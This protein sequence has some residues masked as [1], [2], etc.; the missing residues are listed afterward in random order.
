MTR[1]QMR[2]VVLI[3]LL[4][5]APGKVRA[6]DILQEV[7][8]DVL[9]FVAVH[10]LG[11]VDAKAKW[12]SLEL[13]NNAFSPLAFLK[14]VTNVQDGLNLEGDFLLAVYPDPRGDKS[15]LR[16]GV[17]L[18]VADYARFS[19]SIGANSLDGISTVTIA[20]EDLLVAR[21]GEWALVMDTDQRERMT[22]LVAAS[23]SPPVSPQIAKWKKWIDTND[24]TVI[25][26][27]SG[28]RELLSW[29]D[30]ANGDGKTGDESSD[31]VFGARNAQKRGRQLVASGAN[32]AAPQGVAGLL[33]EYRKWT[34]A[35]PAIAHTIEQA[36]MIGC[37]VRI[38]VDGNNS[39]SAFVGMRVAFNDGFDVEP[40]DAKASVPNWIRDNGD[41]AVAGA[42]RLP[43]A[44]IETLSSA[45][46]Q[47]LAADLKKEEHTELDEESLQQLNESV[48]QAAG[49]IQAAVVLAQPGAQSPP[50]YT[51]NFVAVRVSSTADFLNRTAEVMR[52]WNKANRDADGET[53][54]IF[55]TEE[56]K[57]GELT[58]R[59]YSLDFASMLGGPAVP[60]VR[61]AMEK[62]F[63]PGGK[64]RL[65]VVPADEHT[66]LLAQATPEQVA[67]ALKAFDRKQPVDWKGGELSKCNR[68]LP[69]DSDWRVFVDPHRYND[70]EQRQ[71][72]AITG[73]PVIGG[74]LVKPF[75]DCPPIGIAG[76]VRNQELWID[77]VAL[78]P[79]LKSAYDFL[80][81][82]KARPEVQLRIQRAPR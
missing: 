32:R 76:G 27:T 66:V 80:T 52:L 7:P 75:R 50:V 70:W 36:N 49:E 68:L 40:I 56:I 69:A 2:R 60:E 64:L 34:A 5:F 53:K 35:S 73:V 28:V 19:K 10:H 26:N 71:A 46:L 47:T 3:L 81:P 6:A 61:Q 59:Q 55:A 54:L 63:G 33:D 39:G 31:D 51:N 20:G 72:V 21:R 45:Y 24:I 43:K 48:E 37:G 25:A 67:T 22:Q 78:A 8:N 15:H 29:A 12:L 4:L 57:I 11:T 1:H 9:G 44:V 23:A 42:G 77:A 16:F 74:P 62:L 30:D 38:D 82:A 17:W 65:W 79:T 13:R 41:F 58:A 14:T 18:P